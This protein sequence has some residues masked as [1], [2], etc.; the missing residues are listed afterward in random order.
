MPSLSPGYLSSQRAADL[1]PATLAPGE[2]GRVHRAASSFLLERGL[3]SPI[4]QLS[5]G[6]LRKTIV[7][8][9]RA[10]ARLGGTRKLPELEPMRCRALRLLAASLTRANKKLEALA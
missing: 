5:A 2:I 9:H 1:P 8:L 7:T 6:A 10:N 3:T 4:S